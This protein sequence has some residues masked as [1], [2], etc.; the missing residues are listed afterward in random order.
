MKKFR[1]LRADEVDARVGTC[2]EK[3]FSLLLYKDA[4][5][6]QNILDET[7][8][9]ENWQRKHYEV[10]GNMFCSVGIYDTEK[11][12]WIWKDDCGTE[13]NTEKEKGEASD[14]FKRACFNWGIGRELYTTPFI[15]IKGK[16]EKNNKGQYI[17]LYKSFTVTVFEVENGT[18]SKLQIIGYEKGEGSNVI[19]EY[20]MK[21][22]SSTSKQQTPESDNKP[23]EMT[24]EEAYG[25][26][27]KSGKPFGSLSIEQLEYI[28]DH[29]GAQSSLAARLIKE[30]REN[31]DDMRPINDG[32][33]PF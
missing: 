8:G 12:E 3:G 26:K 27:T 14:S 5:C 31:N 16:T 19:F 4:R 9:P 22:S 21:G 17:T 20:G 10:K 32:D 1:F 24:L 28:I 18:I 13:S 29:G 23:Q 6:D 11:K 2:N 15:Y 33:L 25:F 7:V 30:D